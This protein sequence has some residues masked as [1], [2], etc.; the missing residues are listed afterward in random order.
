M[1]GSP[2]ESDR[3]IVRAA[4]IAWAALGLTCT[5]AC[6]QD[7]NRQTRPA[8][9]AATP[10]AV[11]QAKIE[12]L[13]AQL[14]AGEPAVR[15][16]AGNALIEIGDEALEAL[17]KAAADGNPEIASRARYIMRVIRAATALWTHRVV[18]C[19]GNPIGDAEVTFLAGDPRTGQPTAT[20]LAK[21]TANRRG[22][23]SIAIDKV[24]RGSGFASVAHPQLG[25]ATVSMPPPSRGPQTLAFPLVRK[26]TPAYQ[27]ALKGQVLDEDAKP[28][29][30]AIVSCSV[31]RTPGEGL[32]SASNQGFVLTDRQG[33]FVV[34]PVVDAARRE[35][36]GE[37]IPRNSR[38]YLTV[39]PPKER[40]LFPTAVEAANTQPAS[41]VLERP[42]REHTFKLE[43]PDGTLAGGADLH[44][45]HMTYSKEPRQGCI[46]LDSDLIR[47]GGEAVAGLVHRPHGQSGLS[48]ARG[49]AGQSQGT[50]VSAAVR[51]KRGQVQLWRRQM[52]DN[53]RI[54]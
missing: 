14:G 13:I 49:Q 19:R 31:V 45:V 50:R 51:E 18:D 48:H 20:V 54:R 11:E 41:I 1:G 44:S 42:Q 6:A 23:L 47:E 26:D 36:R 4:W 9:A 52:P 10:E 22:F 24:N 25:E 40:G 29:D 2:T 53:N 8:S 27:R 12:Q 3:F 7:A 35:E 38:F 39:R 28:V 33:R 34:Y 43:R 37:L 21:A 32:I 46:T 17:K 16:T 5:V 30:R 15:Q